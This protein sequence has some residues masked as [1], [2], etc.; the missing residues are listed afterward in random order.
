M[1]FDFSFRFLCFPSFVELP[2]SLPAWLKVASG[3]P[4]PG[5]RRCKTGC[6]TSVMRSSPAQIYSIERNTTQISGHSK[7]AACRVIPSAA[8]PLCQAPLQIV[9]DATAKNLLG[10]QG[11]YRTKIKPSTTGNEKPS[12]ASCKVSICSYAFLSDKK[13]I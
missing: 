9:A 10:L 7:K 1:F 6:R 11:L 12:L 13:H 8:S 5:T 4:Q 2:I 3:Y